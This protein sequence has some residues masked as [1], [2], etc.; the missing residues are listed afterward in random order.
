MGLCAGREVE[1]VRKGNPL[2]LQMLGARIGVSERVADHIL[3][4][5]CT[6]PQCCGKKGATPA[7]QR[8]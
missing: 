7:E 4:E 2:I 6:C 8:R 5:R 1:V 3:I